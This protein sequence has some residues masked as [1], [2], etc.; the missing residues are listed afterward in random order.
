LYELVEY[1]KYNTLNEKIY[2]FDTDGHEWWLKKLKK[3][4]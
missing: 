1:E 2:N 3:D 4:Y